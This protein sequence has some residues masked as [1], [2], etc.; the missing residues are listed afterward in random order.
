MLAPPTGKAG[1]AR[2]ARASSAT[3]ARHPWPERLLQ[4]DARGPVAVLVQETVEVVEAEVELALLGERWPPAVHGVH[5]TV[6][7]VEA[8]EE[9][10]VTAAIGA[11]DLHQPVAIGIVESLVPG[12]PGDARLQRQRPQRVLEAEAVGVPPEPVLFLGGEL[13]SG[14]ARATCVLGRVR[15]FV[16]VEL[17]G[18]A[19]DADSV[20]LCEQRSRGKELRVLHADSGIAG[21]RAEIALVERKPAVGMTSGLRRGR[22]GRRV[23]E[24]HLVVHDISTKSHAVFDELGKID[25]QDAHV[26]APFAVDAAPTHPAMRS[27]QML[28]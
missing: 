18:S 22:H 9:E 21:A 19:V 12:E 8:G 17:G 11:G 24:R 3:R 10:L 28:D 6:L 15:A 1:S 7:D 14:E 20:I 5:V 25:P 16:L 23:K 13:H 27:A 2:W 4:L 26:L